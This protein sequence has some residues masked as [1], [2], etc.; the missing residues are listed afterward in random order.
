MKL[1]TIHN[2]SVYEQL[3]KTGIY[4]FDKNKAIGTGMFSLF[5]PAYL[6]W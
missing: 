1:W 6:E 3:S 5:Q 4:R 2:E